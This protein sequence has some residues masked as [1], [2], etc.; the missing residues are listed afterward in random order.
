MKELNTIAMLLTTALLHGCATVVTAG[1]TAV[2]TKTAIDPRTFIT[3]IKDN[4]LE[5]RIRNTL[6]RDQQIKTNSRIITTV[7]QG[8]VLL[9][10]QALSQKIVN[11]AKEVTLH[12]KGSTD[13]YNEIRISKK[14][15]LCTASSDAWIT[16][17]IQSQLL[18]SN[19]VKLSNVKIITENGEVFLLGLV[20]KKEATAAADIAS[21]VNNVKHVTTA[22]TLLK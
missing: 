5:L 12:V 4:T 6:A 9:T 18:G 13:V 20:T 22:F 16:T 1:G 21:R 15:N 19:Q 2:A 14:I 3:Q 11:R 7:Y 10:G 8:K 17:R